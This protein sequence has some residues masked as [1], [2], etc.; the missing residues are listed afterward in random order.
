MAEHPG[1]FV[2]V[3]IKAGTY[4]PEEDTTYEVD[5]VVMRTDKEAHEMEDNG[6][7]IDKKLPPLVSNDGVMTR[8]D[9]F[10]TEYYG[11]NW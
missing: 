6:Y 3:T 8:D 9:L 10:G 11:D 1:G 4:I 2:E 7:L 5:T